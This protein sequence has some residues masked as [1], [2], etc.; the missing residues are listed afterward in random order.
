MATETAN[1]PTTV[2]YLHKPYLERGS[3][4][5]RLVH[6][7]FNSTSSGTFFEYRDVLRDVV[8]ASSVVRSIP[9]RRD[10][11]RTAMNLANRTLDAMLRR[12]QLQVVLRPE[13]DELATTLPLEEGL[14][15][16]EHFRAEYDKEVAPSG[17][18]LRY[19]IA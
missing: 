3:L 10:R 8:L 15:A 9:A 18:V 14:Q 12:N 4:V 17:Y 2:A 19:D 16:L 11:E 7:Q 5:R 13:Q 6:N 1:R